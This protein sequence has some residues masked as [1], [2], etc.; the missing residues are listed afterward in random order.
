M[1]K[2]SLIKTNRHP[3]DP[4]KRKALLV[5][6]VVSSTAVEGVHLDPEDL[7][8]YDKTVKIDVSSK[9]SR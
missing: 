3:R 2:D 9:P 7:E 5:K 6:A 8:N 4:K 1:I